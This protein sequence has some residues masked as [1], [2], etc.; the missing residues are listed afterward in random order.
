MASGNHFLPFSA[1]IFFNFHC[2][3]KKTKENGFHLKEKPLN[4]RKPF[5]LARKSVSNSLNYEF[6]W[7]RHFYQT[8][9]KLTLARVTENIAKKLISTN[10]KVS[11]PLAR[12]SSF[13][14]NCFLLIPKNSKKIGVHQQEYGSSLK[15]C[16]PPNFHNSFH[17]QNKPRNKTDK[18]QI[19]TPY[20]RFQYVLVK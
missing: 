13:S 12:M 3:L 10:Q 17:L 11:C 4:K 5:P 14:Q 2:C 7:K 20:P 15:N 19:K 8:E 18:K 1:T 16:L 9:N 6:C